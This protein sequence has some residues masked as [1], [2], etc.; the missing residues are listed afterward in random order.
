M[1]QGDFL[2]ETT[3]FFN[4][5]NGT[6]CFFGYMSKLIFFKLYSQLQ[7]RLFCPVLSLPVPAK[8]TRFTGDEAN[9]Q[10]SRVVPEYLEPK[11][12]QKLLLVGP[13]GSGTSTIFKQVNF[14]F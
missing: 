8:A 14:V 13:Q 4:I 9:I 6:V 3:F 2:S 7:I 11:I 12:L 10:L 5:Y 1:G